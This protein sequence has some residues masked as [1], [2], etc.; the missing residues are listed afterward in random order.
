MNKNNRP[1]VLKK[2]NKMESDRW[3]SAKVNYNFGWE[4]LKMKK[5]DVPF[6]ENSPIDYEYLAEMNDVTWL[7]D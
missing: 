4:D 2:V 6:I 3:Q 5:N 1:S 7:E